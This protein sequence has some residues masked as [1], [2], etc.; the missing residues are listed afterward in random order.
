MKWRI[1]M[2]ILCMIALVSMG[3]CVNTPPNPIDIGNVQT[4]INL[5]KVVEFVPYGK[6]CFHK[7]VT[8]FASDYVPLAFNTST[9]VAGCTLAGP[10]SPSP[11]Y[12]GGTAIEAVGNYAKA[13]HF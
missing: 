5:S 7:K 9:C 4:T 13:N 8:W 6:H 3:G 1:N 11:I 12:T 10:A 2:R